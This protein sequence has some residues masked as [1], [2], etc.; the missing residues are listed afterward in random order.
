MLVG[1]V[2]GSQSLEIWI[3]DGGKG[4]ILPVHVV[5]IVIPSI[6]WFAVCIGWSVCRENS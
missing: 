6:P 4:V 2:K 3:M 1:K 5:G